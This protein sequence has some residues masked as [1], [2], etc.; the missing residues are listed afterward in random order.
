MADQESLNQDFESRGD[1]EDVELPDDSEYVDAFETEDYDEFLMDTL[2]ELEFDD[3]EAFEA[4]DEDDL[5]DETFVEKN[6]RNQ[7]SPHD[8]RLTDQIA[9]TAQK[10]G[11]RAT[12]TA[13]FDL[14]GQGSLTR[15][16]AREA[17]EEAYLDD[18]D[19]ESFGQTL[20]P[21]D[22]KNCS[23]AWLE[24]YELMDS[25]AIAAAEAEDG[26]EAAGLIAAII[27]LAIRQVP[28]AY[29][30]LWPAIPV[31]TRGAVGVTRL[32]RGRP[33]TRP[34][35]KM[36]P[37]ILCRTTKQ[38][39]RQMA[40]D[41]PVTRRLAAK[42]LAR[43]TAAVLSGFSKRDRVRPPARRPSRRRR[44]KP[45]RSRRAAYNSEWWDNGFGH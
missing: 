36:M 34:W 42:T 21:R 8:N 14:N 29:R 15:K 32:L 18:L 6:G 11:A 17:F 16:P 20:R 24:D 33:A 22:A 12:T 1:D 31:L 4:L 37:V 43:S 13:I 28:T 30:G 10:W 3:P 5:F 2:G 9:R 7:R 26:P 44:R 35:V 38:L 25:L 41:Q 45:A 27:P 23:A 40:N 19:P 39:A